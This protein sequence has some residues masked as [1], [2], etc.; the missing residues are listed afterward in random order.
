MLL[1]SD[2]A[3]FTSI[4]SKNP[5]DFNINRSLEVGNK[6]IKIDPLRRRL[7][8]SKMCLKTSTEVINVSVLSESRLK[9][10]TFLYNNF[11]IFVNS[12]FV[13]LDMPLIEVLYS[14]YFQ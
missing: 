7:T 11:T 12:A 4:K 1:I 3:K 14:M 2:Y 8:L 10:I 6:A 13:S 9:I 5:A